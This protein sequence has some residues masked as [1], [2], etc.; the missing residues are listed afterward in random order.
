MYKAS[1]IVLREHGSPEKLKLD[2]INVNN[3]KQ[4]EIFISQ[5]AIGVHFHDIYVRTGL[6]KTLKLPGIPGV[7]AVG[8]IEQIGKGEKEFKEGDR[9]AYITSDYGAYASH[10]VLNRN[11]AIK[12]PDN[13]SDELIATN[14]SRALTVKML[15][16]EVTNINS[17]K[18]I[19]VTAAS[20]GVGRLLCQWASFLNIT[21]LG[22]VSNK[23]KVELARSYGCKHAFLYDDKNFLDH[24][25]DIT[26]GKGVD[27]VYDS[28]GFD[29]FD[30]SMESLKFCGHLVNFGQ[31]SGPVQPVTMSSLSKKSLTITRPIIF[32]YIRNIKK[33]RTMSNSVF[34]YMK[35]HSFKIPKAKSYNLE[36]AS[37][38][39]EVLESRTGGGSLYL[40]P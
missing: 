40:E 12:I 24:I 5:T 8:K 33:Y 32:H 30:L 27:V 17:N 26:N 2:T 21:V 1:A 39:H 13:I 28:V 38:A 19:L 16:E 34:E 31:S 7:E 11:L 20:G 3:P 10:R 14:F 37:K 9:I 35:N 29:T 4:G 15:L 23:E 25:N 6:Y 36:K 18:I 22:L